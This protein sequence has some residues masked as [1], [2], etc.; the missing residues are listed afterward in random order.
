M[1]AFFYPRTAGAVREIKDLT[2]T[3]SHSKHLVVA[4]VWTK[5]GR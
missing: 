5:R 3:T 4:Q 2:K 1:G